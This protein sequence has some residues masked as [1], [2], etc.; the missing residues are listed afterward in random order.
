MERIIPSNKEPGKFY[1]RPTGLARTTFISDFEY[2]RFDSEEN[3]LHTTELTCK[4]CL[5]EQNNIML[6]PCEHV[7]GFNCAL[8]CKT[9][10]CICNRM[11][12]DK[13]KIF[14]CE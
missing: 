3:K 8:K 12:N 14:F 2:H 1:L 9:V 6:L 7:L 11:I 5:M 4:H 13:K 10:C